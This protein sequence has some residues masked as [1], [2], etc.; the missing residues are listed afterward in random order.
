MTKDADPDAL[1]RMLYSIMQALASRARMGASRKELKQLADSFH[2][3]LFP[4]A[5][6]KA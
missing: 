2:A 4:G 3:V 1:A 6:E 5:A